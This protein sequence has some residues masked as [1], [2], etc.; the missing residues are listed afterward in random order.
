MTWSTLPGTDD[1]GWPEMPVAPALEAD[2]N[3]AG[4][5]EAGTNAT[6]TN[7]PPDGELADAEAAQPSGQQAAPAA[8]R[9]EVDGSWSWGSARLTADQVRVAEDAYDRFRAAEGRSLFGGYGS[10]GLT[11]AMRRIAGELEFGSLAPSLEESSLIELDVFRARFADLLV[12][13]P[14]RSMDRLARRVPAAISYSFVFDQERYAAGIWTVQ[15]VFTANGFHL[16]ARRN[17]WGSTS[18]RCVSTMWHD[19]ANDLPFQVQFHTTA[20]LEAQE[21][22]KTSASLINDP[23]LPETEAAH[24]RSDLAAAWDAVPEPPG[25]DEISDYRGAADGATPR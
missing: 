21:L 1:E 22:A 23:R 17:D 5:T 12:R 14:D 10:A 4:P 8:P 18:N 16:L 15:D 6:G 2:T 11:T 3:A 19:P 9:M 24:L 25:N 7:E 13:Y 20:S